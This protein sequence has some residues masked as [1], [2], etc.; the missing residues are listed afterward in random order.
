MARPGAPCLRGTTTLPTR[1]GTFE[2]RA[3]EVDGVEYPVMVQGSLEEGPAPLVRLHSECLTVKRSARYAATV[4][5]SST[6][7]WR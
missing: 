3:Y 4:A 6:L 7:H 2:L 1:H 5:S